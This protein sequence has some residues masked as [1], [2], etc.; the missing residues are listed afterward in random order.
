MHDYYSNLLTAFPQVISEEKSTYIYIT[1]RHIQALW[2]EQKYFKN[3]CT[4]DGERIQVI[5]PGIWNHDAGP[6]FIKAHL[7]VGEKEWQGDVE[8]HLNEGDW[9]AHRHHQDERYN[10]VVLHVSFWNPKIAKPIVL[11]NGSQA[12]QTFLE[13]YLSIPLATLLQMIDLDLYPYRKFLGSGRCARELFQKMPEKKIEHFFKA[14]AAW[15]L[16]QKKNYIN[17]RVPA[18]ELHVASGIAMALGYKNNAEAFL[19]MFLDLYGFRDQGESGMLALALGSCGFFDQNYQEKWAKSDVYL[20]LR[21]FYLML[22][23]TSPE[24]KRLKLKLTQIRPMNHPIRR[25]VY[26]AKMLTDWRITS[27]EAKMISLWKVSWEYYTDKKKWPEFC[28]QFFKLIP[29]YEDSYWNTHFSFENESHPENLS[30]MGDSLKSEILVNTVMPI[31]YEEITSR[32]S[33]QEMKALMRF[34]AFMP[35]TLSGKTQYL[36]HRFFGETSKGRLLERAQIE[37]GAFQLHKDFCIHFEASC[38][39]CSFIQRFQDK[40]NK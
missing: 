40:Y 4:M 19:Q 15:R 20:N 38:E 26:M 37:Q 14:A 28:Q 24:L 32:G 31:L 11:Q 10:Q 30:L 29:V 9:Y 8:I 18:K 36:I 12:K 35:A 21:A 27:L 13:N 17:L 34:Y 16:V 22:A 39:G 25:L 7:I 5:S 2:L 1:E 3:L 23:M 33:L 6:D